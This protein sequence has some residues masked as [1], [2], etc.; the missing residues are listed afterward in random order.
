V[1]LLDTNVLIYAFD[2]K[3]KFHHWAKTSVVEAVSGDGAA[4]N[5]VILTE[6]C[7]GDSRPST[8]D[9]RIRAIGIEMLALPPEVAPVCAEAFAQYLEVRRGRAKERLTKVPMPDFFIGAHAS[10]LDIPLVTADPV[11]YR[12]Y[13]PDVKLHLPPE[14]K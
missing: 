5:T 7:V 8:V 10:V 3:D 11:R 1:I 2:P 4:I 13:F 9:S 6:L 12:T 14:L